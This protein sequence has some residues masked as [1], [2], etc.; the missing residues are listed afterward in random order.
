MRQVGH[1]PR[2]LA[3]GHLQISLRELFVLFRCLQTLL[4]TVAVPVEQ[5][6]KAKLQ[7]YELYKGLRNL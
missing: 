7:F 4:E 5:K 6:Q 1:L 3:Q 2:T